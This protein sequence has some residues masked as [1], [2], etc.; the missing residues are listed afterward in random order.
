MTDCN[1]F[2][3]KQRSNTRWRSMSSLG[4][5]KSY[6]ISRP[7]HTMVF[8]RS[9]TY[10]TCTAMYGAQC[11]CTVCAC[12]VRCMCGMRVRCAMR[13]CGVC[14][15]CAMHMYDAY[16]RYMRCMCGH[17]RAMWDTYL[18]CMCVMWDVQCKCIWGLHIGLHR[19]DSYDVLVWTKQTK[20][21]SIV[22]KC[23]VLSV[24]IFCWVGD[25]WWFLLRQ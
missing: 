19:S 23:W 11:M 7:M 13:V 8:R 2:V 18:G 1:P 22:P 9:V 16:V 17:V 12:S 5:F 3:Y 6:E 10:G 24:D 25:F 4:S 20:S 14:V 15:R 21:L